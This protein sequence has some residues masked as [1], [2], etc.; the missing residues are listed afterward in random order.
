MPPNPDGTFPPKWKR[1]LAAWLTGWRT[2]S[3]RRSLPC[4]FVA[5][6]APQLNE[7]RHNLLKQSNIGRER[8]RRA[9]VSCI[10]N[11]LQFV[12]PKM[13][14][15]EARG[16]PNCT[17]FANYRSPLIAHHDRSPNWPDESSDALEPM[18]KNPKFTS[19]SSPHLPSNSS[20]AWTP[21][22]AVGF[23]YR[24]QWYLH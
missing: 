10:P 3:G 2:A 8:L 6:R 9:L 12:A 24:R 11:S 4:D 15:G 23:G 14:Q 7:I 18:T 17:D 13:P 21:D 22:K 16:G 19:P 20:T 5:V 1:H